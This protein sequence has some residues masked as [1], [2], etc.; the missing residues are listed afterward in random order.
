M[1][2]GHNC[3]TVNSTGCRFDPLRKW[4]INLIFRFF[5]LV[6]RQSATLNSATQYAMPPEEKKSVD[7]YWEIL[8]K[9]KKIKRELEGSDFIMS[10]NIVNLICT[11]MFHSVGSTLKNS[12]RVYALISLEM[13]SLNLEFHNVFNLNLMLY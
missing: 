5:A 12:K 10:S 3:L 7:L 2:L 13:Y 11:Y 9:W 8:T 6:S 4:D 1:A